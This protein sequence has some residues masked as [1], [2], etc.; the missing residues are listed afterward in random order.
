MRARM[1]LGRPQSEAVEPKGREQ[2]RGRKPSASSSR[3]GF[4]T[5]TPSRVW[6]VGV[7]GSVGDPTAREGRALLRP[8]PAVHRHPQHR[9]T[10][11][12]HIQRKRLYLPQTSQ[13]GLLAF[14]WLTPAWGQRVPRPAPMMATGPQDGPRQVVSDP[15]RLGIPGGTRGK[16]PDH[17][18]SLSVPSEVGGCGRTRRR[19]GLVPLAGTA[20]L[21]PLS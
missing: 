20:L 15:S 21:G 4:P 13:T 1:A 10:Q 6:R 18:S 5:L 8:C 16:T 7:G 11:P 9:A 2:R 12:V 17:P 19:V 14:H 3:K